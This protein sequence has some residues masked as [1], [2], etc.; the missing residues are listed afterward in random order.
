MCACVYIYQIYAFLYQSAFGIPGS[1][2]TRNFPYPAHAESSIQIHI[3]LAKFVE[4]RF[5]LIQNKFVTIA[6]TA[7]SS[8]ILLVTVAPVCVFSAR[9]RFIGWGSFH[10][11]VFVGQIWAWGLYQFY[12]HKAKVSVELT[13]ENI[14]PVIKVSQTFIWNCGLQDFL[15]WRWCQRR[16]HIMRYPAY[17][18]RQS[19]T[20]LD[21]FR[22]FSSKS[23]LVVN[24]VWSH[25]DVL[26][27]ILL[28][29]GSSVVNKHILM[30]LEV[31]SRSHGLNDFHSRKQIR[32]IPYSTGSCPVANVFAFAIIFWHSWIHE[33]RLKRPQL[34]K[35]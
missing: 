27:G 28:K 24:L 9:C 8:M 7:T 18:K 19:N 22:A 10:A 32:N 11:S 2:A 4:A 14:L 12:C 35:Q 15:S 26:R 34:M 23:S 3:S 30:L 6:A 31:I 1:C 25:M 5:T 20:D 29:H 16:Q 17:N 33:K 21:C 13:R